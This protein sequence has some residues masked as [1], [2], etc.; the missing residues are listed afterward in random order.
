MF[1]VGPGNETVH[2]IDKYVDIEEYLAAVEF[3]ECFARKYLE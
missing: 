3:Y 1:V 2:Q